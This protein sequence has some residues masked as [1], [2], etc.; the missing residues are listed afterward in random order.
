MTR[1]GSPRDEP[2]AMT[3]ASASRAHRERLDAGRDRLRFVIGTYARQQLERVPGVYVRWL[4]WR[5]DHQ[6]LLSHDS[7]LL[8]EGFPSSANSHT[9][10][11]VGFA[12][13]G[14][15]IASHLH[16]GAVIA[17]AIRWGVPTLVVVRDP[18]A[19]VVSTMTRFGRYRTWPYGPKRLFQWYVRLHE[20][21]LARPDGAV[22]AMFDTVTVDVSPALDAL[23]ER[24]G[25]S[26]APLSPEHRDAVGDYLRA[27]DVDSRGSAP[28]AERDARKSEFAAM[29]EDPSLHRWR[30]AATSTYERLTAMSAADTV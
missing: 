4:A 7:D 24:F 29:V 15:Q 6:N 3:A 18:H 14:V 8:I 1:D 13:P 22:V 11:W 23:N 30:D 9:R 16:S 25:T 19:A 21:V 2:H 28:D 5:S 26:F 17:Q 27:K 20:P 12:N 10:A